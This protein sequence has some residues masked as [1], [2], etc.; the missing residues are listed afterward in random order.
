MYF[1]YKLAQID[2]KSVTLIY[3]T[4]LPLIFKSC[5][6]LE[7]KNTLHQDQMHDFPINIYI[8]RHRY[9]NTDECRQR[10]CLAS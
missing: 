2:I 10:P 8:D 5:P 1:I 4:S 9:I 7:L 3:M 6:V